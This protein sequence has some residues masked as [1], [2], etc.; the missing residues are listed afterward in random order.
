[1]FTSGPLDSLILAPNSQTE[2]KN[3]PD[4]ST[5]HFIIYRN[6]ATIYT[7]ALL[8]HLAAMTP[9]ETQTVCVCPKI[10]IISYHVYDDALL[11]LQVV[12]SIRK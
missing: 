5:I 6:A 7:L 4:A 9:T 11:A 1:M 2:G 8:T 12:C 10:H 3:A